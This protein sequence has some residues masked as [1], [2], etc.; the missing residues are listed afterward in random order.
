MECILFLSPHSAQRESQGTVAGVRVILVSAAQLVGDAHMVVL[1][2]GARKTPRM[3]L[4]A[5]VGR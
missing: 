4:G 3:S 2:L 1:C 5:A